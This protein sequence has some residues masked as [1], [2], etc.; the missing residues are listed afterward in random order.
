MKKIFLTIIML[1]TFVLSGCLSQA[2]VDGGAHVEAAQGKGDLKISML[3]INY[4]DSILIQTGKQTILI[5]TG[6]AKTPELLIKELEKLSVT[7]IDKLILTHAHSDHMGGA[8]MLIAPSKEELAAFPY[9]EKISA[10][11]VYDNGIAFGS[12]VYKG[13]LKAL[14]ATGRTAHSLKAGDKLDFGNGVE[15]K[16]FWPSEEYV[17]FVSTNTIAADDKE[18]N[19]NNGS[20]VGKLTYK[21]FSMMF[22]GDCEKASE[23]KIVAGNDAKEL[24]CDVLKGGHHG[25]TTSSTKKFLAAV[26]P[27]SVLLSSGLRGRDTAQTGHPYLK[28]LQRFL[29]A[30][31]DKKN[32]YCTRFNGTITLISD[33]KNFT[34][35]PETKAD[36]LDDWMAYKEKNQVK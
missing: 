32:I 21:K 27:N 26:S 11:E 19:L 31:V 7:K 28:T 25:S 5:D 15:F 35:T 22:T 9:L 4:G 13:Y 36:W 14:N 17:N 8:K 20:L 24:K 6:N 16:V 34:V 2:E 30:G 10:G 12:K 3:N 23:A 18:H 29:A 33:G 1:A